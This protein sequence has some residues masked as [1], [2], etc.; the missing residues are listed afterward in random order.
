M[1]KLLT[2]E[3]WLDALKDFGRQRPAMGTCAGMI[4][5]GTEVDDAR[6]T[7]FGWMPI[8]VRRNAYGSQ[9]H[10][11]RDIGTVDGIGGH[12]AMEMVFIRA[13][14]FEPLSESVEILGTCRGEPVVARYGAHV[15]L[16]FHPELTDDHRIHRMWL[17]GVAEHQKS[18]AGT[19]RS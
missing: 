7:P 18:T 19:R 16:A 6:V 11:F 4:L 17:K 13:P 3:G 12:S 2:S 8:R 14:K 5:M 15:A 1:L 10:S 9:V